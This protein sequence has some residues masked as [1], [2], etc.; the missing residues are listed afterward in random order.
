[1]FSG[2]ERCSL[3]LADILRNVAYILITNA[4]VA[5]INAVN[6]TSS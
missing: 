3:D 2:A 4:G 6:H 5:K 1:M